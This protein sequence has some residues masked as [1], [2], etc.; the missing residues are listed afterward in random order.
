MTRL[1]ENAE[2]RENVNDLLNNFSNSIDHMSNQTAIS[3][4]LTA[5]LIVIEDISKSLA[6]IADAL[7]GKNE[8]PTT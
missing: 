4:N 8:N 5:Q 1:E 2:I 6:I 3:M 7:G